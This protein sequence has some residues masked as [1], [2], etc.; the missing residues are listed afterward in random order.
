MRSIFYEVVVVGGGVGGLF[1]ANRLIQA[2]TKDVV[3]L[4][5]RAFVVGLVS[6]THDADDNPLFN[7][8]AWS[9]G[10]ENTMMQ[11]LPHKK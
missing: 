11:D 9:V 3:V 1:T 5:G 6:T 7:N 4:E 10:E 8:F 2:G